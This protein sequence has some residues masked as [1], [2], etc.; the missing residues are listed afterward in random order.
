[1]SP[2]TWRLGSVGEEFL[3]CVR[4]NRRGG[5]SGDD[6]AGALRRQQVELICRNTEPGQQREGAEGCPAPKGHD[7]CLQG[8][9]SHSGQNH[10]INAAS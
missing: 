9:Q 8:R 5:A 2:V 4:Q 1:M 6:P 10:P 7:L 3:M